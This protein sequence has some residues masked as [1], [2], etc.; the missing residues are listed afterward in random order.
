MTLIEF[1]KLSGCVVDN[2]AG[3]GWVGKWR[4]TTADHPFSSYCGYRTETSAYKAW[5]NDTFGEV[6]SKAL[7]KLLK[8]S[9]K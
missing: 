9:E 7:L 3:E 8:Q 5:L 6:A 4:Y 1:A 2:K